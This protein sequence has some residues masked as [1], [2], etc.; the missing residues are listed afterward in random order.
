M[1]GSITRH[2]VRRR[3]IG[4]GFYAVARWRNLRKWYLA[5]HPLCA[6]PHGDHARDGRREP[7]NEVHH[8]QS[9]AARPDLELVAAN[10]QALC[11]AC[12]SRLT[13]GE[14]GGRV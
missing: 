10:L 7:A 14:A 11:K 2:G 1:S 9:R 8:L 12:H 6:D 3:S 13:R 4:E 5:R